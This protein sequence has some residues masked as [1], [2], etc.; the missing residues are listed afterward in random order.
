MVFVLYVLNIYIVY[1]NGSVFFRILGL[2]KLYIV[3][4][5]C[6]IINV[7]VYMSFYQYFIVIYLI[8]F[9][10]QLVEKSIVIEGL[11]VKLV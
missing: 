10:M 5:Y 4:D 11:L 2:K 6:S 8:I 3:N 1:S 9:I 7:L